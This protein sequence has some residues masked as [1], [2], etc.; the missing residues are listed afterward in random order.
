MEVNFFKPN[1]FGELLDFIEKDDKKHFFLAGGSD[2]NIMLKNGAIKKNNVF[3]FINHLS[4]LK[5]IEETSDNVIIKA[6]T[7]FSEILKSELI[8]NYFPFFQKSLNS[9]ASPLIQSVAT[10][11]GNIANASPTADSIPLLLVMDAKLE[12]ISNKTS[13]FIPLSEFYTGYKQFKLKNNEIL[14]SIFI[15]KTAEKGY[16]PFYSKIG[17]RESLSI[18]KLSIAALKK[19]YKNKIIE[20]KIATGALNE[21]PRRLTHLEYYLSDK[22]VPVIN[23]NTLFSILQKEITPIS[24]IRSDKDYRLSV[25]I[26]LINKFLFEI[27]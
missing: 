23:S 26:N 24:D 27:N 10:I 9:F 15:P 16:I 18:A 7:T 8:H 21:F 1:T 6:G 22:N 2:I 13:K 3:I 4:E 12:L 5:G 19:I 20:I 14:K 25:C 17:S 11:G